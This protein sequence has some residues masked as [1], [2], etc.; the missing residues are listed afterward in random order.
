MSLVEHSER[1]QSALSAAWDCSRNSSFAQIS[2]RYGKPSP[3]GTVFYFYCFSQFVFFPAAAIHFGHGSRLDWAAALLGLVL[4][5]VL[6]IVAK[7]A[8]GVINAPILAREKRE[9]QAA[10]AQAKSAA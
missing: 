1:R 2:A 3:F 5:V 9:R 4:F 10:K 6:A 8:A 7:A